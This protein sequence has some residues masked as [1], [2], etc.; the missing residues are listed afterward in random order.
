MNEKL[1]KEVLSDIVRIG[2]ITDE[3]KYGDFEFE[4]DSIEFN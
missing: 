3:K 1:E 2:F 4:I